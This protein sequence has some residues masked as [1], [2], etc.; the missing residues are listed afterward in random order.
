[1]GHLP[2]Y[3][4]CVAPMS[5]CKWTKMLVSAHTR[6]QGNVRHANTDTNTHYTKV[7]EL[8][9]QADRL[10]CISSCIQ[11][12]SIKGQNRIFNLSCLW[13]HASYHFLNKLLTTY[14]NLRFRNFWAEIHFPC[15]Y[16]NYESMCGEKKYLSIPTVC[17]IHSA[18]Q[19]HMVFPI[20]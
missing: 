8:L 18:H 9:L 2:Y 7:N 19:K 1:M 20:T 15:L 13:K 17:Q 16:N 11:S 10:H 3:H 4:R 5:S 14:Y 12:P 6:T